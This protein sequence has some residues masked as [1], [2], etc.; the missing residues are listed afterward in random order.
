MW[1]D[2]D[3]LSPTLTCYEKNSDREVIQPMLEHLLMIVIRYSSTALIN[4]Q[5]R[6]DHTRSHA[7]HV[8]S[9]ASASPS[10]VFSS[11]AKMCFSQVQRVFVVEHCLASRYSLTCQKEI[12]VTFPDFL[13]PPPNH[14]VWGAEPLHRVVLNMR[15]SDCKHR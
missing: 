2:V 13:A 9:P 4:T 10:V 8:T 14:F 11:S 12:T 3:M 7:G 6:C 15:K 1:C 5:Y